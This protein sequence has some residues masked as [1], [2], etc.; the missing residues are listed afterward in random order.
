[1]YSLGLGLQFRDR[2]AHLGDCLLEQLHLRNAR[3]HVAIEIR[4]RLGDDR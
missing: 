3:G 4:E 2:V 1:M